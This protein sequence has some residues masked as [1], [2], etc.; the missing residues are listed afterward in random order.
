MLL[1]I[2]GIDPAVGERDQ[3]VPTGLEGKVQLEADYTVV[4][5]L[6]ARFELF[7]RREADGRQALNYGRAL[8][9]DIHGRGDLEPG[10]A[11]RRRDA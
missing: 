10:I 6:Q 11:R 1:E 4:E 8:E 9:A 3:F 2:G 7:A 5:I